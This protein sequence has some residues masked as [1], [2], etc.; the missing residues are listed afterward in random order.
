MKKMILF[1]LLFAPKVWY[2]Q[3]GIGGNANIPE[4]SAGILFSTLILF[5][6]VDS[7]QN[8]NRMLFF[9]IML[10][11]QYL[12]GIISWKM[13]EDYRNIFQTKSLGK[14]LFEKMDLWKE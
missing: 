6:F 9:W 5:P 12:R 11:R 1:F 2:A 13:L 4:N 10:L 8:Q 3:D 7:I 14:N